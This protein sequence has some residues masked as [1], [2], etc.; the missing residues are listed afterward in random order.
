[1]QLKSIHIFLAAV[2][3]TSIVPLTA[4]TSVDHAAACDAYLAKAASASANHNYPLAQATLEKAAKEA[5][6]SN[7][8]S[9]KLRVL[10]EQATIFLAQNNTVAAE[11]AARKLIKIYD[12]TS[13]ESLSRAQR[14]DLTESRSQARI[15]LSDSL[16][17]QN[18]SE[19]ALKVLSEARAELSEVLGMPQLAS[20]VANRYEAALRASGKNSDGHSIDAETNAIMQL[21][22]DD[23]R[24][25]ASGFLTKGRIQDAVA[26]LKKAQQSAVKSGSAE[27]FVRATYQ[28]AI[29]Q[30][31]LGDRREAHEE[32]LKAV[33]K[34]KSPLNTNNHYK[35]SAFAVLALVTDNPVESSNALKTAVSLNPPS[36]IQEL[37]EID[38]TP[39]KRPL[40]DKWHECQLI[41]TL[42]QSVTGVQRKEALHQPFILAT[43]NPSKLPVAIALYLERAKTSSMQPEE[44]AICYECAASM[45]VQSKHKAESL[46]PSRLALNIREHLK[47]SD[48]ADKADAALRISYDYMALDRHQQAIEAAKAGLALTPAPNPQC[49]MLLILV[50]ARSYS[51]QK[52][53]QKAIENYD[54]ALSLCKTHNFPELPIVLAEQIATSKH[55]KKTEDSALH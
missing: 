3:L 37:L 12:D 9:Q 46:Q 41:W 38:W 13:K 8:S 54:A 21:E 29:A 36:A 43:A 35:A 15:L 27:S 14:L 26:L 53:Y 49:T 17:A 25:Q 45:A 52:H 33:E 51:K 1:M 20:K 6:L 11:A 39:I 34:T 47:D 48:I 44:K 2:I 32:A 40:A 16:V 18:K 10:S 30:Y 5:D 28:L 23:A 19:E 4:C 42:A 31:L 24:H 55:I 22:A 7:H 50:E